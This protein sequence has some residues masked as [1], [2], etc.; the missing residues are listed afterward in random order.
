MVRITLWSKSPG[1][2][3]HVSQ[4]SQYHPKL[5]Y[6]YSRNH[7]SFSLKTPKNE[8]AWLHVNWK[9]FEMVMQIVGK[10]KSTQNSVTTIIYM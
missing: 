1:V 8:N 6:G 5:S 7:K 3:I 4:K 10:Y 9:S 2:T